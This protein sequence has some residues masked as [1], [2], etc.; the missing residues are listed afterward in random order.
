MGDWVILRTSGRDTMRLAASLATDGFEV[1]T[2]IETRTVRIP[3]ANVRREVRLPIMPSY[4]FAKVAHLVDL[5]ELAAMPVKPRRGAGLRD[6]AHAGFSVM[7]WRDKIPV[8]AERHLTELRK[9]EAKRTP[10]KRAERSLPI[11]SDVK[12]NGGSFGGMKGRVERSDTGHTLVCFNPRFT[13]KI[14][15]CLLDLDAICGANIPAA[16]QAA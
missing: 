4:V 5:L 15:T 6:A 9:I 8:V 7:H 12:V 14:A 13:V 1:W 11:G 2:P 3:R 10:M 16:R